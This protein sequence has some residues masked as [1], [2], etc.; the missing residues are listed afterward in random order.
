MSEKD[1]FGEKLR[2]KAKGDEDRWIAEQEAKRLERLRQASSQGSGSCPRDGAKLVPQ[3]ANLVTM[4][5]CPTCQGIW[6]DK[7]ELEVVVK[8]DNQGA[9]I[10]WVR[11]LFES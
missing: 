4:S 9:V 11:S 7:N 3:K 8:Q 1:R 10:H 6:M 5:V 2:E